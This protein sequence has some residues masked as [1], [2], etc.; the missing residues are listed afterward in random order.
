MNVNLTNNITE[1]VETSYPSRTYRLDTK[2]GRI[3]GFVDEYDAI[4]QLVYKTI[5]TERYSYVIYSDNYGSEIESLIGQDPDF[6]KASL[7]ANIEDSLT[8][9][10]RII[11]ITDFVIDDT[12]LDAMTVS[13][14]VNSMYGQVTVPPIGI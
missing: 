8:S 10:D 5:L 1:L 3:M 13:F 2:A 14:T 6:V 12:N 11:S 9:D 7:R 4:V